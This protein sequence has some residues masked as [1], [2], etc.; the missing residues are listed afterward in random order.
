M[1]GHN[2]PWVTLARKR[3]AV[4]TRM[5]P[6]RYATERSLA[7]G[8]TITVPAE[9]V[10]DLRV[11]LYA[12]LADAA[13]DTSDATTRRERERHPEWSPCRGRESGR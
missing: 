6:L 3:L 13:E 1:R 9:L 11:G 7:M 10:D 4:S 2:L 5:S 8:T 12:C